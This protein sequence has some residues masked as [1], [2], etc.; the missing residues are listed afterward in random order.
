MNKKI[1]LITYS[2]VSLLGTNAN[3]CTPASQEYVQSYVQSKLASLPTGPQGPAGA[4]GPVGAAG[5]AG[6][7]GATGAVGPAGPAG[8]AG[9][10]L[11][12]ADFYAL[13]PGDNVA[14]VAAGAD[15][16][17]P[18]SGPTSAGGITRIGVSTFNLAAVGTYEV[19]FQVSVT[20]PGQL[21]L[22]LNGVEQAFSVVGRATGTSQIVGIALVTT[23]APNSVLTVRNPTGNPAALTITTT[24]GGTA[25]VS[26]HLV[27]TRLA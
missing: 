9:G 3:A 13:M 26:A 11:D 12:F 5:V 22:S 16:S 6:P 23:A 18:R 7:V 10:G 2:L 17:F 14:T 15:V 21:D 8:P 1:M 24:A 4:I 19:M 27:I 20:E 25:A